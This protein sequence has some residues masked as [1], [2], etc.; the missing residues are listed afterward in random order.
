MEA[1]RPLGMNSQEQQAAHDQR[2]PDDRRYLPQ[3]H[4][5]APARRRSSYPKT[6]HLSDVERI[7]PV[8]PGMRPDRDLAHC[9]EAAAAG[10]DCRNTMRAD[11]ELG[12]VRVLEMD[13]DGVLA[14]RLVR[15][16]RIERRKHIARQ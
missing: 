8:Q 11:R 6:V 4:E 2:H 13:L 7:E 16:R 15:I 5:L 10:V 14:E 12:L 1:Y 9:R 3:L